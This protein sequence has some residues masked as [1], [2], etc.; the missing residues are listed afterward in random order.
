M[1]NL[2]STIAILF[3]LLLSYCKT[4]CSKKVPYPGYEDAVLDAWFPYKNK[5]QLVF[6]NGIG[7]Y[8]TLNLVLN[9]SPV[10]SDYQNGFNTPNRG[11]IA[12]KTFSCRQP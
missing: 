1:L 5:Q 12:D 9:D 8:D 2:I 7:V 3:S 4:A 11:C 6:K 10:A